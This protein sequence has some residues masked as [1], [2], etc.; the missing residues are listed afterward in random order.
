MYAKNIIEILK[1]LSDYPFYDSSK[2]QFWFTV[3]QL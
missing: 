1:S 2:Q 3:V